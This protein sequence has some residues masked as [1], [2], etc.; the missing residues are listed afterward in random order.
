MSTT[1]HRLTARDVAILHSLSQVRCL[2]VEYIQWLHWEPA[3]R[4]AAKA[5]KDGGQPH[6]GPKNAYRRLRFLAEQGLIQ[7]ITRLIERGSTHFRRLPMA[8]TLTPKGAMALAAEMGSEVSL[9]PTR[10]QTLLTLEHQLA[11]GRFYAALRTETAYRGRE[12]T[13]WQTD[14]HLSRDYDTVVVPRLGRPLPI[15]PDATFVLDGQRYL[16]EID[17]GTTTLER[18]QRKA[19]AQR[20][21]RGSAAMQDRYGVRDCT[22][23]V[24]APTATRMATIAQMVAASDSDA[25]PHYCF[26]ET[27]R[28]HPARIRRKWQQIVAVQQHATGQPTLTWR[29]VTLWTPTSAEGG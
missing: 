12:L 25:P 20:A 13:A 3:W 16:V 22:I 9:P 15:L 5:A 28:I 4:V 26:G 7:P 19:L 24:V 21:Y 1:S 10:Q 14:A 27:A 17:R 8:Y 18:W 6:Y 2:T 23:L 11:I 29:E